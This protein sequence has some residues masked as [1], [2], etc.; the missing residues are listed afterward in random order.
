M[1]RPSKVHQVTKESAP[2][3]TPVSMIINGFCTCVLN[4]DVDW[5]KS[6]H[7]IWLRAVFGDRHIFKNVTE[8]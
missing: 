4:V 3:E 1:H 8:I 2:V 5:W 6:R 7:F